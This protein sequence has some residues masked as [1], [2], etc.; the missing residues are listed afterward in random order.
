MAS[1]R[2]KHNIFIFFIF[3][4]FFNLL[5]FSYCIDYFDATDHNV[6]RQ[7]NCPLVTDDSSKYSKRKF[8]YENNE[9]KLQIVDFHCDAS[10][11]ICSNVENTF[12]KAGNIISEIILLKNPLLVSV[13]YTNICLSEPKLCNIQGKIA[14]IGAAHSARNMLF[15]DDDGLTRFYPQSLVKQYELDN[16]PE[17]APFDIIATFNSLVNWK[18]P[19]DYDTPIQPKQIDMLYIVLHELMHGLGFGSSWENWFLTDNPNQIFITSQPDFIASNTETIFNGFKETAFDRQL[20]FNND[21]THLTDIT[22]KLNQ[23][24]K[25]NTKFK[26][27]TDLIVN[28][29]NSKQVVLSEYM[30]KISTTPNT[31]S[32][33]PK[34]CNAPDRAIL[35]TTI[36]PFRNGASIS[37]FDQSYITTP[38]FLMTTLQVPGKTLYDLVRQSGGIHPIGPKLQSILECIGYETKRNPTPYRPKLYP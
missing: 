23:F 17:F 6:K 22:I 21:Y 20:I 12:L 37:H 9:P 34:S 26:N 24:A 35:E 38:D 36:E 31:I 10:K 29:I 1:I 13:N 33:Y 30:N 4:T 27:N 15:L 32:S 5:V 8:A 11:E 19:S 16:H 28:F 2:L 25:P 18:F 14:I 3:L 7:V